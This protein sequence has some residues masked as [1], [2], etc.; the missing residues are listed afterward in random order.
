VFTPDGTKLLYRVVKEQPNQFAYYR[1]PGEVM[2]ADLRS[3]RSEPLVRGFPVL[4]Y[5]ISR[6]GRQAVMEASDSAGRARLWLAPLDRSAP[7]RQIPNVE[8]GQPHFGSQGEILFRHNEEASTVEGSLGFVY[9]VLPD[10]TGLRKAIQQ[11]INQFNFLSPIS[12]DGR[13]VHAWG[14]LPGDGPPAHQVYSLDGKPPIS[15]GANVQVAW[16]PGGALLT[17]VAAPTEHAFFVPLAPGQILPHIP[18]GGFPSDEEIA[19]LPGARRIEGRLITLGPTPDVYAF[20][21]GNTQRNLY[22]IPVR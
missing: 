15:V 8:G 17:D 12:P 5:D 21:R 4:N 3:R 19:H 11:P 1:D 2:V 22:R 20:Y 7:L 10:G 9:S 13:W 18:A 6:D 14:P 16:S